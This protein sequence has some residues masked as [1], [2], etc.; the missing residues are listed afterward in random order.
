MNK[1]TLIIG[2][3]PNPGR[4]AYLAASLLREKGFEFIPFGVK[5]GEVFGQTILNE[6]PD[7]SEIHTVTLYINPELQ[8]QYYDQILALRPKRIIFNP[9]TE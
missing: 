2:A 7:S 3:S 4:Y 1:P 6:F 8:K 5:K 9:G